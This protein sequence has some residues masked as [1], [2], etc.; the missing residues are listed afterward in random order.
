M[1]QEG[2]SIGFQ[3]NSDN[4]LGE[5]CHFLHLIETQGE[6]LK[7]GANNWQSVGKYF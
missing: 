2:A 6:V 1:N 7:M 3:V 5:P 4:N